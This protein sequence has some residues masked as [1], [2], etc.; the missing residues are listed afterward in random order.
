MLIKLL[1]HKL[2]DEVK[3]VWSLEGVGQ[4]DQKRVVYVL[5]YHLLCLGVLDLVLV[6]DVFLPDRFHCEQLFR[7]FELD[8]QD[9]SESALP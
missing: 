9:C 7:L 4:V 6:H 8:Q 3:L 5:Q 2:H 1:T